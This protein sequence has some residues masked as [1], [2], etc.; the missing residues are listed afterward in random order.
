[1]LPK[2][3]RNGIAVFRQKSE[4]STALLSDERFDTRARLSLALA[5]ITALIL[6][7]ITWKV[8]SDS[9]EA[10]NHVLHTREVLGAIYQIKFNTL[11]IEYNTQGL[12][13]TG[14]LAL[15]TERNVAFTA[16]KK[17]MEE[18]ANLITANTLQD[19]RFSALQKVIQQR[20]A[21]AKRIEELV[22]T[23][24]SQAATEYVRTVPV[25]ETRERVYQILAEMETQE[26]FTLKSNQLA[27]SIARGHMVAVS[28]SAAT[29]LLLLLITSYYQMRRHLQRIKA[30]QKEVATSEKNLAITLMSIGDAVLTTD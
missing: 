14:D 30:A 1:M 8:A 11:N 10:D 23:Q 18:L 4:P 3:L 9:S 28:V 2:F 22:V 20:A 7:A 26:R 5:V 16:R 27:Q 25:K 19:Q 29:L 13:F 21:I 17:A 12:R 24:G 15:I 6:V